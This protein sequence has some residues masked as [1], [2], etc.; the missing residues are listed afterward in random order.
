MD[1]TEQ[2]HQRQFA[3]LAADDYGESDDRAPLVLLHGLT[4]D[5][6][7]WRPVV[8]Q[9]QAIDPGRR[10]LAL[11]LPGHGESPSDQPF[12]GES[13]IRRVHQAIQDAHLRSPVIVGHSASAMYA[14][15][16]ATR[17]PSRGVVNVDQS[18]QVAPFLALLHSLADKITGPEFPAIWQMFLAG[19]HLELL[20][21]D[22]QRLLH[23]TSTPRQ[24]LVVGYWQDLLDQPAQK[25]EERMYAGL[26]ALRAAGLPYLVVSGDELTPDYRRWLGQ[27]LPQAVIETWPTSSHFPHLAHPTRFAQCLADTAL[28]PEAE[29]ETVGRG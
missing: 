20:P 11:D 3:G 12:D 22:A 25:I 9:L 24:D 19:M 5:R 21:D 4:F 28:W 10:V 26:A 6:T 1:V 13:I 18:L 29:A 16:Y 27:A 2:S 7:S 14:T 17:F 23:S 15:F 8:D